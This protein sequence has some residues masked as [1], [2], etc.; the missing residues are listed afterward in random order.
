MHDIHLVLHIHK[1]FMHKKGYYLEVKGLLLIPKRVTTYGQKGYYL[2]IT[3]VLASCLTPTSVNLRNIVLQSGCKH[4]SFCLLICTL[5]TF[6]CLFLFPQTSG[7][8]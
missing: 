5:Q 7:V 3:D 8:K 1:Q 6:V 2:Q 4:F